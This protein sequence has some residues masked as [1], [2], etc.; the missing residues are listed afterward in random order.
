MACVR[1]M[2]TAEYCGIKRF[3]A[4]YTKDIRDWI[5]LQEKYDGCNVRIFGHYDSSGNFQI[6]FGSRRQIIA[7]DAVGES[8]FHNVYTWFGDRL[9]DKMKRLHSH[10]GLSNEE[11]VLVFGELYGASICKRVEYGVDKNIK[12][13]MVATGRG[14]KFKHLKFVEAQRLLE[15]FGFDTIPHHVVKTWS[16]FDQLVDAY[17]EKSEGFVVYDRRDRMSKY[18][19]AKFL[20]SEAMGEKR[21]P[22]LKKF[23][24]SYL[25][26]GVTL[27]DIEACFVEYMSADNEYKDENVMDFESFK[28]I[29]NKL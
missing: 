22:E 29:V 2:E 21:Y 23:L 19:H 12:V 25:S 9:W 16:D 27:D 26:K 4:D 24:L 6:T 18:K 20:V 8:K 13:Y 7:R 28:K 14:K 17:K 3:S 5:I 1:T 15:L 10:L 11:Y